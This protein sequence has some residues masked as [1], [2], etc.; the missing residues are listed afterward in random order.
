MHPCPG[1]PSA[2]RLAARALIA[3]VL[4]LLLPALPAA[5]QQDEALVRIGHFSRDAGALDVWV[6]GRRRLVGVPYKGVSD[7]LRLDPGRHA[8]AVRRAGAP[9]SAGPLADDSVEAGAGE[10]RTVTVVGTKASLRLFTATDDLSSPP[11][12]QAKIRGIHASP[13]APA[14]DVRVAGGPVL[15]RKL[16][17]PSASEY[18]TIPPGTYDIQLV[19]SGTNQVLVTAGGLSGKAGAIYTFVGSGN[20]TTKIDLFPVL[21]AVGA[22]TLPKGAIA[23]GGGGTAPG[24][25]PSPVVVVAVLAALAGAEAL[26]RRRGRT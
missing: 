15:F 9:S 16:T 5:A 22:G 20:I 6:D 14:I 26:R 24:R 18:V 13:E 25:G 12:G 11:A 2:R 21:D 7:Y 4:L 8:I 23:T 3:A 19:A 1:P 10:A 17:F